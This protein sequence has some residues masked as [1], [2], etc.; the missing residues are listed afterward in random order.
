MIIYFSIGIITGIISYIIAKKKNKNFILW[1]VL[2]ILC[3]FILI[4]LLY[5]NNK[6]NIR[7]KNKNIKFMTSFQVKNINSWDNIK[8]KLLKFYE[9]YN[10]NN[11]IIDEKNYWQLNDH[12]NTG[13]IELKLNKNIITIVCFKFPKPNFTIIEAEKNNLM[14]KQNKNKIIKILEFTPA[15]ESMNKNDFTI[16]WYQKTHFK[17]FIY[18]SMIILLVIISIIS[19]I[20]MFIITYFVS[21]KYL[22]DMLRDKLIHMSSFYGDKMNK[23]LTFNQRLKIQFDLVLLSITSLILVCPYK[24]HE[25]TILLSLIM[26][27]ITL[28]ITKYYLKNKNIRDTKVIRSYYFKFSIFIGVIYSSILYFFDKE[29]A[30]L[31]SGKDAI[32]NGSICGLVT[33]LNDITQTIVNFFPFPIDKFLEIILSVQIFSGFIFTLYVLVYINLNSKYNKS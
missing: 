28:I 24:Y 11:V 4:I 10:I 15:L 2:S 25:V 13:Y 16:K 33:F 8:I 3:P 1:S 6:S 32:W 17:L 18:I 14:L 7:C 29:T 19:P 27:I 21:Y 12:T 20:A 22:K 26:F 31:S 30:L 23:K 5:R 9:Q